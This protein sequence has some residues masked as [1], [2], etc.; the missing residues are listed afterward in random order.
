[1]IFIFPLLRHRRRC[2]GTCCLVADLPYAIIVSN[3]HFLFLA[4]TANFR[5]VNAKYFGM[6]ATV[7]ENLIPTTVP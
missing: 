7:F 1:M 5:G 6:N 2:C 3:M 4:S